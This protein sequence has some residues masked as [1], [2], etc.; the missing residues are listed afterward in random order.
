MK[1]ARATEAELGTQPGAVVEWDDGV[2][3]RCPCGER[4]V[5]VRSPL[6]PISFDPDGAL[7]IDGSIGS[8]ARGDHGTNW[9]HF[10]VCNGVAEMCGDAMCPGMQWRR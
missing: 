1:Y 2:V 6:H 4:Q 3:F 7:T 9:C 5:Y 10:Y 8:N